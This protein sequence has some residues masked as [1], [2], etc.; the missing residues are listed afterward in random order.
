MQKLKAELTEQLEQSGLRF[1]STGL[2]ED[3]FLSDLVTAVT[4]TSAP[5]R[6]PQ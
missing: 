3:E 4:G 6:T 5:G 1:E 2:A